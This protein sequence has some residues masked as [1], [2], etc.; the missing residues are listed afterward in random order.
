MQNRM[1]RREFLKTSGVAG[2]AAAAAVG[3]GAAGVAAAAAVGAGGRAGASA[4]AAGAGGPAG[5]AAET[6]KPLPT[7]KIGSLEVSR[8]ILGSNPFWGFSHKSR[9]LDEE[10][11]A[12][13]TDERI[14]A[15][16]EEAALRGITAI[17]SAPDE[18]W[19]NLYTQYRKDGGKL[20]IWIAQCHSR[21][22]QMTEEIDRALKTGASAVF[23]QGARTEEQFGKDKFDVLRAWLDQ[24]RA[25]GVPAGFAA[26]WPEVHP[27]LERRK[28]PA[29]FYYQCCY[30][31]SKGPTY[32]EDERK[33]AVETI[34]SIEKPVVAYKILAAGRLP[35]EKGFEL[36]SNQ[37]R[38]KD[39]VC[40]GVYV[41][42]AQDQIRQNAVL[43][44]VLLS[45]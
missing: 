12:Y 6:P 29:D 7:F 27:E 41:K 34:R 4:A 40:V 5:A 33:K 2:V 30:N 37:I 20:R 36:A 13:H 38:R 31:A 26:H 43:T 22:E 10:M 24:I 15:V 32:T 11:K 14:I 9:E 16:L 3:G 19:C 21:A 44:D 17:T 1:N 28:F 8:L 39:G 42:D 45:K 25:G 23:I 35:A 18:R